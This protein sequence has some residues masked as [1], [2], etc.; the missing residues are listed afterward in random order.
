[1]ALN[2]TAIVVG[3]FTVAAA[4]S[5]WL[6]SSRTVLDGKSATRMTQ[7]HRFSQSA[8]GRPAPVAAIYP[9]PGVA[10]EPRPATPN[11]FAADDAVVQ[12]AANEY[13]A[14]TQET[15]ARDFA[16]KYRDLADRF[17]AEPTTDRGN[18]LRTDILGH[19]SENPSP[20]QTALQIECRQTICRVQITGSQPDKSKVMDDIQTVG[21][22]GQVIGMERPAGDGAVISD[23]Y[24]AMH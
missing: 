22:F 21:G 16:T 7:D 1:V 2:R 11:E 5:A 9:T 4:M 15:A 23:L 10:R 14:Q 12:T 18:E 3:A 24:L 17:A 6:M 13:A 20:T 8:S 19:L